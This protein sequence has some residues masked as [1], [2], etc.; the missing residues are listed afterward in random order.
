M[1]FWGQCHSIASLVVVVVCLRSGG[2]EIYKAEGWLK[3][4]FYQPPPPPPLNNYPSWSAAVSFTIC[5]QLYYLVSFSP[6]WTFA[7][8]TELLRLHT[9][10][11]PWRKTQI[12]MRKFTESR[13]HNRCACLRSF[14]S[15]GWKDDS[16]YIDF[17]A[18]LLGPSPV[19]EAGLRFSAQS[20][21]Q[22]GLKPSPY[23]RHFYFRRI[24]FRTRAEVSARL[25]GLNFAV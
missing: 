11:Q 3:I 9:E 1:I 10:F 15:P 18:R 25:T 16:D 21:I 19:S 12:S 20:E 23:N 13:K 5:W 17:S 22:S 4:K 6:G 24:S 8:P 14:F 7:P 2:G